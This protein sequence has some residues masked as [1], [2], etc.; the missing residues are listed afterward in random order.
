[1]IYTKYKREK[2]G[3][4]NICP[5]KSSLTWDHVPPQGSI[6]IQHVEQENI[7]NRLT[8][9]ERKFNISQNGVKFRTLC[10]VCN[11][12]ELGGKLDPV[13]KE[14]S[15]TITRFLKTSIILPSIVEIETKPTALIRAVL[16]HLLAAKIERDDSEIDKKIREFVFDYSKPIPNEINLF[17]WIYPYND[18]VILRDFSMPAVRN[19]FS[20]FGIFSILKFFPVAYLLA[21]IDKYENLPS[22]TD[23]RNMDA[24]QITKIILNLKNV[25]EQDWPERVDPG[26]FIVGGASFNSS[27]YA[28]PRKNKSG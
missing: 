15:Q 12:E 22:L 16:G 18:I 21:N 20:E 26:N 19:K 3:L 14:F 1:M 5:N 7:F 13:L 8:Q 10:S 25:K 27:V 6:E 17:Y 4:C 2:I 28:K 23:Y 9:K 24:N 11:N